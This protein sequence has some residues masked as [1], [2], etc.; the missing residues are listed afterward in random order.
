MFEYRV[1]PQNHLELLHCMSYM[2][3]IFLLKFQNLTLTVSDKVIILNPGST[4]MIW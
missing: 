1:L 3:H 2:H 4:M